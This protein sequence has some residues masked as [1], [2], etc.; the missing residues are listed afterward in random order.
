VAFPGWQL[1]R[2]RVLGN[3]LGFAAG[4]AAASAFTPAFRD[5]TAELERQ[6]GL[7]R[8]LSPAELAELV[9]YGVR[10]EGDAADEAKDWGVN[11]SRFSEL[12]KITGN[13][14]GPQELAELWNRGL[15]SERDFEHGVRTGRIRTEWIDPLK[16]F[17]DRLLSPAE[18][19]EAAVRDQAGDVNV[20]HEARAAGLTPA[21]FELLQKVAG[22]APPVGQLIELLQ[23][24]KLSEGEVRTALT[25][26]GV[27]PQYLD[28]VLDLRHYLLP[29]SDVI[30]LAVH[31]VYTPRL[32][33]KYRLDEE[34]PDELVSRGR[35][36]GISPADAADLWAGHWQPP[37]AEQG[38]AMF[39]RG[40]ITEGDVADLL[41]VHDYVPYW[42]DKL[43]ELS[44]RV[45]GRIDLR[46]LYRFGKIDRAGLV[47]G[48]VRLGYSPADAT[49]LA[50]AAQAEKMGAER[51]LTK[52][53]IVGLYES[54]AMTRDQARDQLDAMGYDE[55][56][57]AQILDLADARKTR[58]RRDVVTSTVRSRYLDRELTA[59]DAR[60]RLA[61]VG[62]P[63][64]EITFRLDLWAFELQASPHH[65]TEAQMRAAWGKG[66]VDEARYRRHL[67]QLGVPD[68]E[69]DIM[70]ATYAPGEH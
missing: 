7:T 61:A 2:N 9:V 67:A 1:L 36:L 26:H 42:R 14:P 34:L 56:E 25:D 40:V 65:I 4:T 8:R 16:G 59:S 62:L 19:A 70:V 13:P 44:Y 51:D 38:F 41:R 17:R 50:Q 37:S 43:I 69:A 46:R 57:A 35:K 20:D 33:D 31:E 45:P 24:G 47:A 66:V 30:R 49:L 6:L 52:A 29:P 63:D 28:A 22:N 15:I 54:A 55:H 3:V 60:A 64:D 32:R 48:Y 27:R 39:H 11:P 23:R 53:E 12:V 21:R 18:L 5:I 68:D 10:T 58:A